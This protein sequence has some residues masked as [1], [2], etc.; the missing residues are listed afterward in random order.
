MRH[1]KEGGVISHHHSYWYKQGTSPQEPWEQQS[2]DSEGDWGEP[3]EATWGGGTQCL[4]QGYVL[5]VSTGRGGLTPL[6]LLPTLPEY[7]GPTGLMPTIPSTPQSAGL[8][9]VHHHTPIYSVLAI[10]PCWVSYIPNPWDPKSEKPKLWDAFKWIPRPPP[11]LRKGLAEGLREW[12]CGH[13]PGAFEYTFEP[14]LSRR[15]TGKLVS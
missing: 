6:L 9:G 13:S 2:W 10:S 8:T 1:R 5:A 4:Q 7:C 11:R 12:H 3:G 14:G 15:W